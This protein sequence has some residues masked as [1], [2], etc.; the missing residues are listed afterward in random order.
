MIKVFLLI[1]TFV[2]HCNVY[3]QVSDSEM[4]KIEKKWGIEED[5]ESAGAK[6]KYTSIVPASLLSFQAPVQEYKIN[7]LQETRIKGKAGIEIIIPANS[8][9]L[10][11]N[12]REKSFLKAELIEIINDLDFMA[13]GIDLVWYGRN[14]VPHI[15]ESGGMFRLNVLFQNRTVPLK[16]GKKL[17]V[18]IP[19]YSY[20]RKMK[21]YRLNNAGEW[22][23]RGD[24]SA[25]SSS[26]PG[27]EGPPPMLFNA[28]NDYSWYNCD[29]PNPDTTCLKGR[30][31]SNGSNQDF[32]V[33]VVGIDF[34]NAASRSADKGVFSVNV[35]QEKKV[36]LIA[37]DFKGNIGIIPEWSTGKK[38]AFLK[39]GSGS[40][41]CTDVG[42]IQIQKTSRDILKDRK[43]LLKHLGLYD[44]VD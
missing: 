38:S 37:M 28:M 27:R 20:G 5:E 26:S 35:P 13:S 8:F 7:P 19:F 2:L 14:G 34:K 17:T 36:K 30:I 32:T 24:F 10:P 11:E 6:P 40:E 3:P 12:F 33:T 23:D 44:T 4:K 21:M 1:L 43:K 29:F 25:G 31:K 22:E 18:Q 15:F 16:K 39:D 41:N 9:M 42:T